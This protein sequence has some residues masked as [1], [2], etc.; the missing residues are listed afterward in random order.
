MAS[1]SY[2]NP[3]SV[4]FEAERSSTGRPSARR[5]SSASLRRLGARLQFVRLANIPRPSLPGDDCRPWPQ[6]VP[7]AESEFSTTNSRGVASLI[8]LHAA[9]CYELDSLLPKPLDARTDPT[10]RGHTRDSSGKC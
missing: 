10:Y 8:D 1:P 7:R 9:V 2:S 4:G 6:G 3:H 5:R